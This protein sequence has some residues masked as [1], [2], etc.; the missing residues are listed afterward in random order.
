MPVSLE[1]RRSLVRSKIGETPLWHALSCTHNPGNPEKIRTRIEANHAAVMTYD[2]A[3]IDM[4]A[5]RCTEVESG[6]R[7]ADSIITNLILSELS[8]K[9]LERMAEGKKIKT[10]AVKLKKGKVSF[11][12]T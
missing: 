1:P 7:N 10:I 8:N 5:E 4:M 6:A 9:L 11:Q 2:D 3:M 12:I